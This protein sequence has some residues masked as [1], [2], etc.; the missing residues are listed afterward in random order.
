MQQ[1]CLLTESDVVV[2]K[3]NVIQE[4]LLSILKVFFWKRASTERVSSDNMKLREDPSDGV[5]EGTH[6]HTHNTC[7]LSLHTEHNYFTMKCNCATSQG[8]WTLKWKWNTPCSS[9]AVSM[10]TWSQN[11]MIDLQL[12]WCSQFMCGHVVLVHCVLL[13]RP[14]W[15]LWL[16]LSPI[17][18]E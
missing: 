17:P 8:L 9:S 7:K 10:C 3:L 18:A 2:R 6:T 13:I 11:F 12:C 15:N 14:W 1:I 4:C 16:K 5:N